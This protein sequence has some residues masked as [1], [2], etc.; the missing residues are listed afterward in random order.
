MKKIPEQV[1]KKIDTL[2]KEIRKEFRKKGIVIPAKHESGGV[3]IDRYVVHKN[4]EG[5]YN[6]SELSGSPIVNQINLPQ[7]AILVANGLALG[8]FL[9][10]NLLDTDRQ[11]GY[12]YFEETVQRKAIEKTKNVDRFCLGLAK[13]EISKAKKEECKKSI[14]NSFEKLRKLA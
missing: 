14:L 6:V 5:F 11:Y 2:S 3:R 13:I 9:D 1:Y 10:K 7:T 4:Q 12:D 8:R